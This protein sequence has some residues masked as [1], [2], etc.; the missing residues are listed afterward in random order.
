MGLARI[1]VAVAVAV[2]VQV[3]GYGAGARRGVPVDANAGV[4]A[5]HR[6]DAGRIGALGLAVAGRVLRIAL[7]DIGTGVTRRHGGGVVAAGVGRHG[8]GA[9]VH[10]GD[11]HV[12]IGQVGLAQVLVAVAVAVDVQVTTHRAGQPRRRIAVVVGRG[13]DARH[14]RHRGRIGPFRLGVARRVLRIALLHVGRGGPRRHGR[15]PVAVGVG[16]HGL[17]AAVHIGHQHVDVG[18]VGLARI[19][20]AVAVA[21]DVQV[22]GYGAGARGL[23][24]DAEVLARDIGGGHRH[25][26]GA[27]GGGVDGAGLVLTG[28]GPAA[29]ERGDGAVR[30]VRQDQAVGHVLRDRQAEGSV[31]GD[32]RGGDGLAGQDI[33]RGD[34]EGAASVGADLPDVLNLA[35]VEVIEDGATQLDRR[36]GHDGDGLGG[37]VAG[38]V[39]RRRHAYLIGETVGAGVIGRRGVGVGAGGR[40]EIGDSAV[41]WGAG[42]TEGGVGRID[43]AGRGITDD[44]DVDEGL[45]AVIDRFQQQ[46]ALAGRI[47]TT[48]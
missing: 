34:I 26:D 24:N 15:R 38:R 22:T 9:A 23:L 45:I 3:T 5:R 37:G 29:R 16:A 32:G 39:P 33:R 19:L 27:V 6:A 1:L 17:G 11:Q 2:D 44:G 48:S 28:G 13:V 47:S 12:D 10:I 14:R 46:P 4:A 41:G 35:L 36:A 7:V 40:V 42:G 25:G 31:R 18:Q 20:V 21:V 8:L 30:A 43:I